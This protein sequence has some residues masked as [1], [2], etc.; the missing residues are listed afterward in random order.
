MKEVEVK[1]KVTSFDLIKQKLIDVGCELTMPITQLDR[2][3][4]PIGTDFLH[5]PKGTNILRIRK[6]GDRSIFT[7]KQPQSNELDC[8]EHEFEISD[9]KEMTLTLHLLG[10]EERVTVEKMRQK[11]TL[12][13]Y[14]VCIDTVTG[15]GSFIEIESISNDENAEKVQATLLD[16]LISLGIDPHDRVF[17]GYDTL[18]YKKL[19][20]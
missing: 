18:L 7:L 19:N 10:Y 1:A 8:I 2:I 3:F 17:H 16:E 4:V 13:E 11:C 9:E 20:S 15:L 6:Q 12:K 14:E 5:I